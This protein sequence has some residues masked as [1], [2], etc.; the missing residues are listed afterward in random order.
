[1]SRIVLA[2]PHHKQPV[3]CDTVQKTGG[4]QNDTST[5]RRREMNSSL[6]FVI[7]ALIGFAVVSLILVV[8]GTARAVDKPVFGKKLLIKN[9]PT[10][11]ADNKLVHLGKDPNIVIGPSGG[12]GDPTCSGAGGGGTSALRVIASGGADDVTIPLPCV[13]WSTNATNTL[14]KYKDP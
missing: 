8:A 4:K 5:K 3:V 11:V 9:P 10:G 12:T 14:Y 2:V 1:R 7:S 13:G 6:R